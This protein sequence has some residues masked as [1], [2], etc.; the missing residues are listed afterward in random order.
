MQSI[1]F[2]LLCLFIWTT[3]QIT[4]ESKTISTLQNLANEHLPNFGLVIDLSSIDFKP[5]LDDISDDLNLSDLGEDNILYNTIVQIVDKVLLE[6]QFSEKDFQEEELGGDYNEEELPEAAYSFEEVSKEEIE[7]VL[8]YLDM[9][10]ELDA[11]AITDENKDTEFNYIE[12]NDLEI[13][14]EDMQLYKAVLGN[15][16]NAIEISEEEYEEIDEDDYDVDSD[17]EIVLVETG[18]NYMEKIN[19]VLSNQ[20]VAWGLIAIGTIGMA[21]VVILS[22]RK[23]DNVQVVEEDQDYQYVAIDAE[24]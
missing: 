11:A 14:V 24:A 12:L 17:I 13:E 2:I 21:I 4:T 9:I 5:Y 1:K 18:S 23:K 8:S 3:T 16:L 6:S 15:A 10:F 20:V 7:R 22:Y 19:G